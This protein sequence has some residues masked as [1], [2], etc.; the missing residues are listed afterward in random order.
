MTMLVVRKIT[1]N[2]LKF[3]IEYDNTVNIYS[4]IFISLNRNVEIKII[5]FCTKLGQ[6]NTIL[7]QKYTY[8]HNFDKWHFMQR[9]INPQKG[10][11]GL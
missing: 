6:I 2:S 10:K 8:T 7:V 9:T 4:F 11:K 5:F 1:D 3:Q